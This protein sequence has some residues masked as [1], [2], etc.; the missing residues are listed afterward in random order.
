MNYRLLLL[1]ILLSP[2]ILTADEG[3]RSTPQ[4]PAAVAA[5]KKY[6]IAADKALTEYNR[7]MEAAAKR[8]VTDLD[9]A[10]KIAVKAG[11][12]DEVL[13][14][15]SAKNDAEARVAAVQA[16]SSTSA[17]VFQRDITGTS[18]RYSRG[19]TLHYGEHGILTCPAWSRSDNPQRWQVVDANSIT[20]TDP[21]GADVHV[22][23]TADRKA[24]I[25]QYFT[26]GKLSDKIATAIRVDNQS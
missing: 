23:F 7:Q 22:T 3:K 13:A 9:A 21:G 19:G 24:C 8:L 26:H 6:D 18:W 10:T 12:L 17:E 25:W 4:S 20:Q 2:A 1:I 16:G 11:S 5:A 14:I 15:K